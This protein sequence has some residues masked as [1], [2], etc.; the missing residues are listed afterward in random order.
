MVETGLR[1]S[2]HAL[3]IGWKVGC[4]H[5]G[6]FEALDSTRLKKV[7]RKLKRETRGLLR[8]KAKEY[9]RLHRRSKR[10]FDK[11]DRIATNSQTPGSLEIIPG[12]ETPNITAETDISDLFKFDSTAIQKKLAKAVKKHKSVIVGDFFVATCWR[13]QFVC[14]TFLM[15]IFATYEIGQV[16]FY[17]I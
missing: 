10:A 2:W 14:C 15:S 16:E 1:Y 13:L 3:L 17:G 7:I 9:E 5:S 6:D 12:A 8:A 11:I 4:D